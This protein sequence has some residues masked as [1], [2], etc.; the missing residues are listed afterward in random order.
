MCRKIGVTEFRITKC[1]II[2]DVTDSHIAEYT[3]KVTKPKEILY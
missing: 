3:I 1:I 2:I